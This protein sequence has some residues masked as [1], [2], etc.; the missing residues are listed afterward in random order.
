MNFNPQ[1]IR[2]IVFL[3]VIVLASGWFIIWSVKKSED[4]ARMIFKWILTGLVIGFMIWK[5]APMV[6]EGGYG[7]GGRARSLAR[8]RGACARLPVHACCRRVVVEL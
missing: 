7:G 8:G 2:G 1:F 6:G 4:P 3:A 5:V